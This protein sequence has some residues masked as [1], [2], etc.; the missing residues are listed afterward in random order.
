M[1]DLQRLGIELRIAHGDQPI[2]LGDLRFL[3]G[4]DPL[5]LAQQCFL[6]RRINAFSSQTSRR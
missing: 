1:L 3:L 5:A 2:A 4:D 6:H